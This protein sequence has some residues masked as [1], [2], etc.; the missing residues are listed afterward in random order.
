MKY[1]KIFIPLFSL[2][3]V[4][5]SCNDEF[6]DR[7]PLD[8]ISDV[9]FW[10]NEEQ[11]LLAVNATYDYLKGKNTVDM[12]NLGD[13]TVWPTQSGYQLIGSGNY[14][15]DVGQLNSEW[16][17]AYAGIRRCNH[18]LE[19][20]DKA[21]MPNEELKARYSSEVRF[22]R[23]YLYS[24][25]TFFFGDVPFITTAVNVGDEE[26]YAPRDPREEIVEWI[27]QELTEA[28]ENLPVSYSNSEFGRITKGAALGWKSRVALFYHQYD[29][30][31]SAAREVMDLGV[32]ELYPDYYE[33][34]V[35]EGQASKNPSN[36]ETMLSRVYTTDISM[37]NLSREIHVPDQPT[38]WNPTQSLVDAYLSID[39]RTIE[40]SPLYDESTYASIFENRDPRMKMTL[41]HPGHPWGGRE[42]GN[43]DNTNNAIFT[44]PKFNQ[45]RQG[46]TTMTGYYFSKYCELDAVPTYNRD[47]N[48][49]I[50]LRYAEILLN[51]AE[52]RLEQGTLTQADVD[53]TINLLRQRVGMH[54]MNI[55]ELE[56]WGMDL[57][58]EIRRER[59][60]ELAL[61]GQRYFDIL[62]W[63]QG[64]LLAEDIK[65][66][67]RD[68]II[69]QQD[70]Q[71]VPTD[72]DGHIIFLTGRTFE[73]PKHYL[74]PIP[75]Q[76]R[77]RNPNLSQNEGW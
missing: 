41:L 10:Q 16:V 7:E 61:E 36:R 65:G 2:C 68:L 59:R 18:F 67:K 12:E 74:W 75:L 48:D 35:N 19:N 56:S 55:A 77:D 49:I 28:A 70:V 54:P 23:A 50:I 44:A 21:D 31:E 5:S 27:L 26:L 4:F 29:V 11:L 57:R 73:A 34:F 71:N 24:Y 15:N 62:R 39:G 76:Q 58:E 32:Y 22:I 9:A 14:N 51:Y 52:A 30:A 17:S 37:H 42:D 6:L 3:M 60:I 66:M 46:S 1:N 53:A 25:L 45:D 64:H 72:E 33:L 38:R 8:A 69:R 13:N 40:E 63:E 47:E 20:Y 43:P